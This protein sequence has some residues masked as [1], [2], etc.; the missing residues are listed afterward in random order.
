MDD[1]TKKRAEELKASLV[2]QLRKAE[3]E[4]ARLD[5]AIPMMKG[6]IVAVNTLLKEP[7]EEAPVEVPNGPTTGEPAPAEAA[8]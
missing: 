6:A 2:D 3:D 5:E 7:E 8:S 4:R 1:K